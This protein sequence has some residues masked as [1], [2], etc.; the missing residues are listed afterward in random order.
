MEWILVDVL[1]RRPN[2]REA[3]PVDIVLITQAEAFSKENSGG[4]YD[5]F[6]FWRRKYQRYPIEHMSR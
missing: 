6:G 1:K 4:R 2:V 3:S 5:V